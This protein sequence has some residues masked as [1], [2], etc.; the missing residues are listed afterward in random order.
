MS[1]ITPISPKKSQ[2]ARDLYTTGIESYSTAQ[3]QLLSDI[4][5]SLNL[6]ELNEE[7]I[8]EVLAKLGEYTDVGR[9][10]LGKKSEDNK[11]FSFVGEWVAE[12]VETIS[13]KVDHF[14]YAD[15]PTFYDEL[16]GKGIWY[17]SDRKDLPKE[18]KLLEKVN[19]TFA[20]LALPVYV[21]SKAWGGLGYDVMEGPRIWSKEDIHLMMIISHLLGLALAKCPL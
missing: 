8:N 7:L 16:F 21:N 4:A 10:V 17:F 14:K 20:A 18:L 2:E 19:G 11:T 12:G 5:I 15:I 13:D 1:K 3:T 9:I 6:D